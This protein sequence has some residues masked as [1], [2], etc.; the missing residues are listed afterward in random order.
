MKLFQKIGLVAVL[1][2]AVVGTAACGKKAAAEQPKKEEIVIATGA[3]PKP[4]AYEEDGKLKGFDID[5]AKAVFKEL[6]QYTVSFEK[7]EFPS[8]LAGIDTGRYQMGA[9]SFAKSEERTKKYQFSDALYNNPMGIILPKDSTIK[10]F[11][12]LAGKKTSG[13]PAVSYSVLIEDYNKKHTDNPIKLSYTEEDMVKQF[14]NVE[15]GKLDFKLES[16]I[17]ANQV[18]EDQKLNLKTVEVPQGTVDSRSAYSYFVFAKTKEGKALAKKVNKVLDS[19]R[20]DGT[21]QKLSEQYFGKDYVPDASE[22]KE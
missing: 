14:Q 22:A 13:E 19:F 6:P 20:E 8:I 9:N 3:Y 16:I 18:I 5:L 10:S 4:Y 15:N 7:T 21:L 11:D 17:I 12:D 1:S 2:L